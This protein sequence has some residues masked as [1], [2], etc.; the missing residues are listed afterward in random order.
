MKTHGLFPHKVTS[1]LF[2]EQLAHCRLCGISDSV[3][4]YRNDDDIDSGRF[5]FMQLVSKL[6]VPSAGSKLGAV[7]FVQVSNLAQSPDLLEAVVME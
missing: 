7:Q 3:Y 5:K 6:T 1:F 4:L 2:E